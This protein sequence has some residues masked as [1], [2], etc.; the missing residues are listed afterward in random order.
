[1]PPFELL[2]PVYEDPQSGRLI[3]RTEVERRDRYIQLL[4]QQLAEPHPLMRLIKSCLDND[5]SKRPRAEELLQALEGMQDQIVDGYMSHTSK[6]DDYF[7]IQA[8]QRQ[9]VRNHRIL[10]FPEQVL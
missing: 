7:Q 8:L 4:K 3:A 9:Q 10:L 6:L 1:M 2:P 5:P